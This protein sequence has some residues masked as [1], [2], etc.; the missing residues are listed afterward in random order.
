MGY[1]VKKLIYICGNVIKNEKAIDKLG[2][3]S[4][5]NI[6]DTGNTM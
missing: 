1:A 2:E 6:I 4:S 5:A 3:I